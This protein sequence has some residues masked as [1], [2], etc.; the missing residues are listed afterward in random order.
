MGGGSTQLRGSRRASSVYSGP[1]SLSGRARRPRRGPPLTVPPSVPRPRRRGWPSLSFRSLFAFSAFDTAARRLRDGCA[2]AMRRLRDGCDAVNL[3][4]VLHRASWSRT[5]GQKRNKPKTRS[6][7]YCSRRSNVPRPPRTST[8]PVLPR[9]PSLLVSYAAKLTVRVL[10]KGS[11]PGPRT[12]RSRSIAHQHEPRQFQGLSRLP[13]SNAPQS[14]ARDTPNQG[15]TN[16]ETRA[17]QPCAQ[18]SLERQPRAANPVK[19]R[20]QGSPLNRQ[21]LTPSTR[22]YHGRRRQ[23]HRGLQGS[24]I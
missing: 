5:D 15:A 2:T 20:E 24:R 1:P 19:G 9:Q 3:L 11:A 4:S 13:H 22:N 17:G 21:P 10:P 6:M 16:Q 12:V 7:R 23:Y 18:A 8:K 14:R